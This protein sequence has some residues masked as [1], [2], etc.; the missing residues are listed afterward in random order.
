MRA[1]TASGLLQVRAVAAGHD[2]ALRLAARPRLD[3]VDLVERAVGVVGALDEQQ[4][5]GDAR[6]PRPR[7]ST[8]GTPGSSHT[9]HQP[10]NAASGSSWWRAMRSR[11]PSVATPRASAGS[12]RGSSPRR[13]RAAPRAR[14]RSPGRCAAWTR[15]IE[16]PSLCPT[17]IGSGASSPSSRRGGR[18]APPRGRTPASAGRRAGC[19]RPWPNRENATTR[20]PVASASA[21][22][23]P[24]P[25]ADRAEPL[26]QEDEGPPLR[27]ALQIEHLDLTVAGEPHAGLDSI[28]S[29]S[30]KRC[31]LPVSVR[32]S[33][34]TNSTTCGY[35]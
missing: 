5:R 9:S 17:R 7:C 20:R 33:S 10:Q 24:A 11:R 35:S 29:R 31:T 1:T 30:R 26:V 16:P 4:R 27:V 22:G 12:P 6:R 2:Q 18:R 8:A 3:A 34:S 25:E 14:R 19:D 21:C 32:G 13:R 23:K 15:A 28:R